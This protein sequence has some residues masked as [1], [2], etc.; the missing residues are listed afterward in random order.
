MLANIPIHSSSYPKQKSSH[1]S[2]RHLL[3]GVFVIAL[4]NVE[5]DLLGGGGLERGAFLRDLAGLVQADVAGN[6]GLDGLGQDYPGLVHEARL[7]SEAEEMF[8]ELGVV[9]EFTLAR[10]VDEVLADA[11]FLLAFLAEF[12]QFCFLLVGKG[13]E[14]DYGV[15]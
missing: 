10:L 9:D 5:G 12:A 3:A 2:E 1:L 11:G 4:E 6:S 15:D 8:F 7:L 14:K 13:L